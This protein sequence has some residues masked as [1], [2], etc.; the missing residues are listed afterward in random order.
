MDQHLSN[1]KTNLAISVERTN[2]KPSIG[3]HYPISK[4]VI[5]SCFQ[6]I[7][8]EALPFVSHK[9]TVDKKVNKPFYQQ[10]DKIWQAEQVIQE[11]KRNILLS[12]G[13]IKSYHMLEH[14]DGCS[15]LHSTTTNTQ[16]KTTAVKTTAPH[17]HNTR[18]GPWAV[19]VQ[20]QARVSITSAFIR[21]VPIKRCTQ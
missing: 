11:C 1:V 18:T 13:V 10:R 20:I 15:C 8:E 16:L 2:S 19:V 21:A 3:H 5:Y 14:H 17:R 12:F 9:I 6:N 7:I 4:S